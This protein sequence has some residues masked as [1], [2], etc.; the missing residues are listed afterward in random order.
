MIDYLLVVFVALVIEFAIILV[1]FFERASLIDQSQKAQDK[2]LDE[3]SKAIKAVISKNANEYVMTTSIDK[4][5]AEEKEEKEEEDE[6][7]LDAVSDEEFEKAI[8]IKKPSKK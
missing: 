5:P 3:L 7:P 2:L 1:L 6:I 4:I 8:G